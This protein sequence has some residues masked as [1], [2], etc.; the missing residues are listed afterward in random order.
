MKRSASRCVRGGAS[1][2]LD[3]RRTLVGQ[4]KDAPPD[5]RIRVDTRS[6]GA[7]LLPR[8]LQRV[9]RRVVAQPRR[10][11]TLLQWIHLSRCGHPPLFFYSPS[12]PEQMEVNGIESVHTFLLD[13]RLS[14]RS[15][16]SL[17]SGD[18][19]AFLGVSILPRGIPARHLS[20]PGTPTCHVIKFK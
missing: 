12:A 18:L 10:F 11:N 14:H 15:T 20:D 1:A 2:H 17:P 13:S 9:G 4:V 19:P 3:G 7:A 6:R 5:G 16:S 8:W